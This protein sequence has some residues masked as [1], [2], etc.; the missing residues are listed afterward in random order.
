MRFII[1]ALLTTIITVQVY[2]QKM[3]TVHANKI[4]RRA[5]EDGR[6][7]KFM[8]SIEAILQ[9]L[10]VYAENKMWRKQA[11]CYDELAMDYTNT[12]QVNLALEAATKGLKICDAYLEKNSI[13]SADAYVGIGYSNQML[14]NYDLTLEAYNK[15]AK[16]FNTRLSEDDVRVTECYSHIGFA[17]YLKGNY[18]EAIEWLLKALQLSIKA[19]GEDHISLGGLYNDI[20]VV[21]ENKGDYDLSI[22]YLQKALPIGLKILG[23][24]H[25]HIAMAYSNMSKVYRKKGMLDKALQCQRRA[26]RIRLKVFGEMSLTTAGSY[27]SLGVLNRMLGKYDSAL[28]YLRKSLFVNKI[29][30]KPESH[31][32]ASGYKNIGDVYHDLGLYDSAIVHHKHSIDIFEK[33]LGEYHPSVA[34]AYNSVGRDWLKKPDLTASIDAFNR[35]IEANIPGYDRKQKLSVNNYIEPTYLVQSLTYKG[36]ALRLLYE[37]SNDVKYLTDALEGYRSADTLIQSIR[38]SHRTQG[39]KV[40]FSQI[41]RKAY[42]GAIQTSAMLHQAKQGEQFARLMFYFCE[43]SKAGILRENISNTTATLLGNIPQDLK[44]YEKELL[45]NIGTAQSRFQKER[46]AGD[47]TKILSAERQLFKLNTTYDSLIAKFEKDYPQYYNLKHE[48]KVISVEELQDKL[49]AKTGLM[50]FFIGDVFS[51]VFIVTGERFDYRHIENSRDLN[52]LVSLLRKSLDPKEAYSNALGTFNDFNKA[53]SDLYEG[54]VKAGVETIGDK[55][56][57]IF[58]ADGLLEYIPFEILLTDRSEHHTDFGAMPYLLNRFSISYG[59]SS[60]LLFERHT[61]QSTSKAGF[62]AFAPEYNGSKSDSTMTLALGKFRDAVTTLTWNKE[63]VKNIDKYMTGE[64]ML[65]QHAIERAFKEQANNY[66]IIHLAMHALIDD[67]NPMTSKLVFT[68]TTDSIEDGFLNAYEL[69]NM[70]LNADLVV[71]SACETG[72]GKFEKGEGIMSIGRAFSYAGCPSVVMSHWLVDDEATVHI[73]DAF[74]KNLSEGLDKDEALRAAKLQFL[75]GAHPLKQHPA[76]WAGFVILGDVSPVIK[77]PTLYVATFILLI[78]IGV[79][80]FIVLRRRKILRLQKLAA[81]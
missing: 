67:E 61:Q 40:T 10:P 3:D 49:S 48:D 76:F 50:E 75:K 26:L 68:S 71:L 58:I 66:Q 62:I 73:M 21:Y 18:D 46:M 80:T 59:Y 39:D 41:A 14:G 43:K 37:K 5:V 30:L 17:H 23:D 44:I 11:N 32:L 7:G 74:Y 38:K 33:T 35:S 8:E 56:K 34:N 45:S 77:F 65:G 47:S 52:M 9:I 19:R 27:E 29:F 69:Y 4:Y 31:H 25:H 78:I 70:K 55:E 81:K 53:S 20:A 42:E 54:Y 28:F 22:V 13:E 24:S 2:C 63:E 64:T 1:T 79:T 57:I 6:A 60:T 15:A 51:Y 16:L 72:Y 12:S 36:E